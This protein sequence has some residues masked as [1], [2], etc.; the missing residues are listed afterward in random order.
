MLQA[1]AGMG[2]AAKP[3]KLETASQLARAQAHYWEQQMALWAGMLAG[4]AGQAT[5][6]VVEA[7][8]GDRRFHGEQWSGNPWFNLLKQTYLLNSRLLRDMVES[9]EVDEKEKHK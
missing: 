5:R 6:P 4:A 9:A 7:E 1:L 8:R 2:Q 3:M